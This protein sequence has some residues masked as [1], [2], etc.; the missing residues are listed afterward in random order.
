MDGIENG[1]CFFAVS[2]IDLTSLWNVSSTP[3]FSLT[4]PTL[5]QD[6]QYLPNDYSIIADS[7]LTIDESNESNE[8]SSWYR[9]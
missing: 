2:L 4:Q 7:V 6:N 8:K 3:P 9:I 5:V 1:S